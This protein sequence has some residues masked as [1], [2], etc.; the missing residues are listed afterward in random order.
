M[1]NLDYYMS[2][3]YSVSVTPERCTDGSLCYMARV[4]ELH[5]CESHG[6]TPEQALHH[7]AEAK[8]LFIAS[9]LEDGITPDPPQSPGCS[10]IWRMTPNRPASLASDWVR[11]TLPTDAD[12]TTESPVV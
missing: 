10:A 2:L 7:L 4:V 11:I 12:R 5:G 6:E 3:P 9:M 8:R 1:S